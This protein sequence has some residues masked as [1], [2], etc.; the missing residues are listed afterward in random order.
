VPADEREFFAAR[1]ATWDERFPD[2]GP[3]YAA[4]VA[5]LAP[6]VGGVAV[7]IGC[8]TGRAL[9]Y[10]RAAVGPRGTVI[11][12]DLTPQMLAEVAGRARIDAPGG[13]VLADAARLPLAERSCDALFAAGLLHHLAD[14]VAGLREFARVARP[15]ARLVIFHPIGRVA[16]AARHGSTPHPD[17]VRGEVALRR[18]GAAAGWR[19]ERIDDGDARYLALAVRTD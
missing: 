7:D 16:L 4:A 2:D 5:E 15:Q 11:G 6:P 1:A 8:G 3:S 18:A 9:P 14:P 10:L 17:D 19:L 13:L 12:L